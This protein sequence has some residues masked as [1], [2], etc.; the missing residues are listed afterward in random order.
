MFAY[1]SNNPVVRKDPSGQGWI[2][3]LIIAPVVVTVAKVVKYVADNKIDKSGANDTEKVLAKK[4][5][6]AAYQVNEAKK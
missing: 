6:I 3:D 1:C 2:T 5:Y 4:D